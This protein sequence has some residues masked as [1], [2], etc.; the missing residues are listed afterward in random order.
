MITEEAAR[1]LQSAGDAGECLIIASLEDKTP[2]GTQAVVVPSGDS[3]AP[4]S[5][6]TLGLEGA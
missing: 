1:E 5:E 4:S 3:G 6:A 2:L